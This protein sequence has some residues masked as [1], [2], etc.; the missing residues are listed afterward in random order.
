MQYLNILP[1]QSP[2]LRVLQ[3]GR[4]VESHKG[5]LPILNGPSVG[6]RRGG[7]VSNGEAR[8]DCMFLYS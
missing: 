4:I 8:R 3:T 7:V 6:C 5:S 1:V 2:I